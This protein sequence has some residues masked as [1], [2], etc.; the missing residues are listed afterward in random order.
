M[1]QYSPDQLAALRADDRGPLCERVVI[2]FTTLAF[3]SVCL[4]LFTR[5]RFHRTGWEDWT[6]ALSMV[7]CAVSG[8]QADVDKPIDSINRDMRL[9]SS[10]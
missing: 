3:V 10:S 6:I 4:R 8:T 2:T 7:C 9:S 1:D 5:F